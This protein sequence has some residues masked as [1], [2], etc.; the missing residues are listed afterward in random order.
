VD[1]GGVAV[2]GVRC[3]L[4][5]EP[6]LAGAAGADQRH[7]PHVGPQQHFVDLGELAAAAEERG[8]RHW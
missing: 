7:Q 8:L 6:A 3:D 2:G 1:A 4:Q 5:G